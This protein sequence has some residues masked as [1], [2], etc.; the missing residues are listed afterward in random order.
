MV[1]CPLNNKQQRGDA[2]GGS[3]KCCFN[4]RDSPSSGES[5]AHI[6]SRPVAVTISATT[7]NDIPE[8]TGSVITRA[9]CLGTVVTTPH[10]PHV[11]AL[12]KVAPT[13]LQAP[14]KLQYPSGTTQTALPHCWRRSREPPPS[15]PDLGVP[16]ATAGGE[17]RLPRPWQRAHCPTPPSKHGFLCVPMYT[18]SGSE[19]TP[20]PFP[21]EAVLPALLLAS[22]EAAEVPGEK[23]VQDRAWPG[24]SLFPASS[25]WNLSR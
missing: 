11:A 12:A 2:I 4:A 22:L 3:Q 8:D 19:E 10:A 6:I 21:C 18:L 23:N 16:M 15:F 20:A 25:F 14:G 17:L 7:T 13:S 5:P 9:L 24:F 1:S